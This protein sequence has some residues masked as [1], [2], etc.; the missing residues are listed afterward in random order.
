M[1]FPSTSESFGL[2]L[3]E[4]AHLGLPILAPELDYVRDVCSPVQTFD[5][6]SPLSIARAVKR[7]LKVPEPELSLRSQQEFWDELLLDSRS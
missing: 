3:V 1:I 7:F 5:P 6:T 2:P 4:A